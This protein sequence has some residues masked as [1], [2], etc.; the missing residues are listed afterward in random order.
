MKIQI[1][2]VGKEKACDCKRLGIFLRSKGYKF[3]YLSQF[4]GRI[5]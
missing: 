3:E 2:K 5:K 1:S 4:G